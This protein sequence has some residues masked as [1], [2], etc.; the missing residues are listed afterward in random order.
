M[1]KYLTLALAALLMAGCA[2]S[3][4]ATGEKQQKAEQLLQEIDTL[5]KLQHFGIAVNAAYPQ[6]WGSVQLN[7]DY[8][9]QV[10]GDAMRSYL[11]YYGRAY[12][13]TYGG[14]NGLNFNGTMTRCEYVKKRSRQWTVKMW[15]NDEND[16]YVYTLQVYPN[17]RIDLT[18]D[19]GH[20][21]R[22]R[23]TG[24]L[25]PGTKGE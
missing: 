18:V 11:P 17:G 25:T 8:G 20:R 4:K 7:Y 5:M 13:M 10:N 23:F 3:Q 16:S 6:G 21:S 14:D 19:S 1:K 2:A 24:I 22:I 15:A 9:L 12:Q